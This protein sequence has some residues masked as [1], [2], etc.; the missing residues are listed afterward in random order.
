MN[1]ICIHCNKTFPPHSI[2]KHE[3]SCLCN[4]L[5]GVF[6][7]FCDK[8]ILKRKI[9]KRN[10]HFFC[11]SRCYHNHKRSSNNSGG[12]FNLKEKCRYCSSSITIPNIERHEKSCMYNDTN[13][14]LCI[15]C[16]K[17]ILKI[18]KGDGKYCTT[19]CHYEHQKTITPNRHRNCVICNNFF[20]LPSYKG[21]RK[22][23]SRKCMLKL[24]QNNSIENINC[25]A[26]AG[27][28]YSKR[29]YYKN[30]LLDSSWEYDL[31]VWMD[32]NNIEWIRD[33]KNYFMWDD[34][35]T[36]RRYTP[37]FLLPK[38]GVYLDPKNS[39]LMKQA[40]K[41]IAFVRKHSNIYIITGSVKH[42]KRQINKILLADKKK[43]LKYENQN[44]KTEIF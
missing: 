37:D 44:K 5:N 30:I 2:K 40:R 13:K 11:D 28:R 26:R 9:D 24:I 27:Y 23:C 39:Y 1:I 31:A 22:T 8:R 12:G 25:G 14:M 33:R 21:Y 20:I 6:C 16:N 3:K 38:Y 7:H 15:Y 41:K 17:R 43:K 36:R 35:G 10:K 34:N 18:K 19:K 42:L 29:I 4:D 32:R